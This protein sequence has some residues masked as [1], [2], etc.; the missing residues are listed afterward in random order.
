MGESR[1]RWEGNTLVIETTN[2]KPG[3]S[4]TNIGVMGSPQG[5][6]FPTSEQMKTTERLTRLNKDIMLYEIK[7][8][9]PV[10]LT[11][12]WTVRYPAEA[13]P[14]ATSG[15]STPATRAT[16]R[17]ATTSTRRAPSARTA[18]AEAGR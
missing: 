1:G 10:V 7:T 14:D 5:N 17:F 11:R 16:A 4:A 6:R 18:A 2:Y 8:E 15:G 12:P 13:R 9:D 3:A